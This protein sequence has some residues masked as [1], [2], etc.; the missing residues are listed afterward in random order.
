MFFVEEE[1]RCERG[2]F[3][4]HALCLCAWMTS[5]FIHLCVGTLATAASGSPCGAR[6]TT[7]NGQATRQARREAS[8]A[9]GK[10]RR[11]HS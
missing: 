10:A 7:S 9:G 8:S 3:A 2:S 4:V 11:S 6:A 1:E 5:E